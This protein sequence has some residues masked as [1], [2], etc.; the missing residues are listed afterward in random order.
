MEQAVKNGRNFCTK[1]TSSPRTKPF[2]HQT[3]LFGYRLIERPDG[4]F[5]HHKIWYDIRC[6]STLNHADGHHDRI[7]G[8][9]LS[10]NRLINQGDELS[11]H[12][13]GVNGIMRSCTVTTFAAHFN[14]KVLAEC[15][16][17]PRHDANVSDRKIGIN[18]KGKDGLH[19]LD[20]ALGNHFGGTA[21][22][23]LR[24]LKNASPANGQPAGPMERQSGSKQNGGMGIVAAGVH[25]TVVPGAKG[26]LIRFS[27]RQ[28][29]N[30]GTQGNDWSPRA[31]GG[32]DAGD[33]ASFTGAKPMWNV[34]G[35]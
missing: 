9:G 18:V 15:R 21:A 24:R 30:I 10:W 5:H 35:G 23:F 1:G 26:N 33:N 17:R 22:G 19:A 20:G 13:D 34:G 6:L 27:N 16:L 2:N 32:R 7:A 11:R 25:H 8:V 28:S 4:S 14:R 12:R 3:G 31:E 29:I